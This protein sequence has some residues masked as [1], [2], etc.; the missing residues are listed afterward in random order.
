M[1]VSP[2]RVAQI[3]GAEGASLSLSVLVRYSNAVGCR[4][5]IDLVNRE[6]GETATS[7]FLVDDHAFG[8]GSRRQSMFET[9]GTVHRR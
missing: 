5:D 7:I 4:L 2:S 8:S 1:G 6:S 9:T 3:E